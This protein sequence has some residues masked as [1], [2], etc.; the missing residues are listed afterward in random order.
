VRWLSSCRP[1]IVLL[2]DSTTRMEHGS[3]PA[4]AHGILRGLDAGAAVQ[5]P[6]RGRRGEYWVCRHSV[7]D[8]IE[9][10]R[11]RTRPAT[12]D[13]DQRASLTPRESMCNVGDGRCTNKEIAGRLHQ[14]ADSEALPDEHLGKTGVHN[15]SSCPL[16][17]HQPSI[18][19]TR[20]SISTRKSTDEH[21]PDPRAELVD[22]RLFANH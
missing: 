14:R 20:K 4:R 16:C 21:G 18:D 22:S 11:A 19:R 8:L 17:M 12:G 13:A 3:H 10:V 6:A 2:T 7:C 9:F 5:E 1:R 15:R